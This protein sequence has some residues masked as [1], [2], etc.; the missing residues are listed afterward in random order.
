MTV[1]AV[2]TRRPMRLWPGIAIVALVWLTRVAAPLVGVDPWTEFLLRVL[3]GFAGALAVLIWWLGFS[4]ASWLERV[5]VVAVIVGVLAVTLALGHPSMFVWVLWYAAPVLSLALVVGALVGRSQND[6]K[7]LVVMAVAIV[8]PGVAALVLRIPGVAGQGVAAFAW[9]WTETAEQRLLGRS[10]EP[11]DATVREPVVGDA[12]PAAVTSAPKPDSLVD[13]AAPA[14][15]SAATPAQPPA[16][17]P[18]ENAVRL[19]RWAGFRGAD[20]NGTLPGVRIDPDWAVSPPVSLWRRPVGPGW[21]SFAVRG[22]VFYTQEQ[23]GEE[24]IVSAYSLSTGEPVWRHRDRV[25]LNDPMGGPGP[26]GTPT[27]AGDR[28]YTVGSTGILNALSAESGSVVW[29]RDLRMD[30]GTTIPTWGYSSSPLIVDDLVVVAVGGTLAAF[31]LGDGQPRWVGPAGG[32]S[33]SSPQPAT[34]DGVSQVLL[35][36]TTGTTSVAPATGEAL[37]THPWNTRLPLLPI[38]QPAV[39]DGGTVLIGDNSSGL[40]RL[41][42]SR[43]DTAWIVD[44]RWVSNRLKPYFNDFIVHR[45]HA[46]GFDG[47]ILAAVDLANGERTWKGGRYGQGQLVLLPDQ[48]VL[49]VVTEDGDLALVKA[50]PDAFTEIARVPALSGKTWNHPVLVGDILLVRNGEEMAAFRLA[51]VR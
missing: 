47:A 48:D 43:R 37:W 34:I 42:V 24:E 51:L 45:G 28:V 50:V 46:Y 7:R 40:R 26:R 3:G 13:A 9:R 36:T 14:Q 8:L 2:P 23:R 33:Y 38:V 21:A 41:A 6:R 20:R 44:E 35:P 5:A 19:I 25:R 4:R 29:S 15:P 11:P 32:D 27:L 17:T 16:V 10:D 39:L 31:A 22:N 49:L 12:P 1:T 18:A 30:L